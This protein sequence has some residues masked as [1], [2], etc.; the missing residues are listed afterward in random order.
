[1]TSPLVVLHGFTGS[2]ATMEMIAAPFRDQRRVIVPDL[3]GHGAGPHL[4]TDPTTYSIDTMAD[5]V[6]SL[7]DEPFHLVG[8]SMG[9]R[10]ALALCCQ[11]PDRVLSLSLIGASAGLA[12]EQE[13]TERI[14]SDEALAERIVSD[15]MTAFV[16]EWMANPLFT[17]QQRLGREYLAQARADRLTNDA[18]GLALSLRGAGTGRMRPLHRELHRCHMPVGLIVGADDP[19]FRAIAS[20]LDAALPAA[21]VHTIAQAGHAAHV[22]QPTATVA[23]IRST[24]EAAT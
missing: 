6:A 19:K 4:E 13:R 23:A 11:Q 14:G 17:T 24:I 22:E 8:Y 12:T 20:E 21:T 2:A 18:A 7:V 15:G 10:V 9:G 16:E 5:T 1:M 3:A